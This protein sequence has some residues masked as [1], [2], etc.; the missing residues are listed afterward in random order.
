MP[1][2]AEQQLNLGEFAG[3]EG[4][5]CPRSRWNASQT[6]KQQLNLG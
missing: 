6:A 4:G 2:T 1:A 3:W 5:P